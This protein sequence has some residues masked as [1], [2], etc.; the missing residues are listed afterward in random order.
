M[1]KLYMCL[2]NWPPAA[3][4]DDFEITHDLGIN[5]TIVTT[6]TLTALRCSG[7]RL[8][9]P[10][11]NTLFSNFATSRVFSS[12]YPNIEN[13]TVRYISLIQN[14]SII[15][16][17]YGKVYSWGYRTFRT[18]GKSTLFLFKDEDKH[19]IYWIQELK[20]VRYGSFWLAYI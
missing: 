1:A 10:V 6:Y 20:Q 18:Y 13:H 4:L 8:A 9:A 12:R 17:N 19:M 16:I 7:N 5:C 3:R 15:L 2:T 11:V 14:L